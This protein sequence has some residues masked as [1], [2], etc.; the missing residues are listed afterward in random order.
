MLHD[1]SFNRLANS[2]YETANGA[3]CPP[4]R[5][6]EIASWEGREFRR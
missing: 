1:F 3:V 2:F 5:H 6:Q 4:G